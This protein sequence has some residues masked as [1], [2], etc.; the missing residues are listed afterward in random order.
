MVTD[1]K[2]SCHIRARRD[3]GSECTINLI[4]LED[5]LEGAIPGQAFLLPESGRI[6]FHNE[7]WD[8]DEQESIPDDAETLELD[9]RRGRTLYPAANDATSTSCPTAVDL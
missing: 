6:I 1:E 9:P 7:D 2:P 5:A 3:D 4:E 8:D